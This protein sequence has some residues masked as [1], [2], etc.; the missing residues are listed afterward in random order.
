MARDTSLP[1]IA[2][3]FAYSLAQGASETL[4]MQANTRKY[5]KVDKIG[6]L[7]NLNHDSQHGLLCLMPECGQMLLLSYNNSGQPYHW[8]CGF[9]RG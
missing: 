6:K 8:A 3:Y 9:Q 1:K 5:S 7:R 2:D 4:R